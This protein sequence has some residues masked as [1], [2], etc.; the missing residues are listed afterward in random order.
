MYMDITAQITDKVETPITT[1][2]WIASNLRQHN[3]AVKPTPP[4]LR[5]LWGRKALTRLI[6]AVTLLNGSSSWVQGATVLWDGGGDGTSWTDA[7]NWS[8]D[9]IP[10]N[11]DRLII[12]L[13]AT[14]PIIEH[15]SGDHTIEKIAA[16]H[17]ELIF[18]GG[19]LT[20]TDEAW[21]TRGVTL[22]NG[23]IAVTNDMRVSTGGLNLLGGQLGT[24]TLLKI[25]S[26]P[27]VIGPAY[28]GP[29]KAD[30]RGVFTDLTGD[31]AADHELTLIGR[32]SSEF[33]FSVV[34]WL[35]GAGGNSAM[36]NNGTILLSNT[37]ESPSE[38]GAILRLGV[39]DGKTTP[40]DDP[41]QT[42]L[43]LLG[44]HLTNNGT[45]EA[46]QGASIIREIQGKGTL[47]NNP[48]GTIKAE[49]GD[50]NFLLIQGSNYSVARKRRLTGG[51][52]SP[53]RFESAGGNV[54]GPV[55]LAHSELS[56]TASPASGEATIG[57]V[58][59]DNKL[60]T[61]I[62]P[63]TTVVIQGTDILPTG[64][65]GADAFFHALLMLNA[66]EGNDTFTN[67][68]KIVLK[69][70]DI[71]PSTPQNLASA[72]LVLDLQDLANEPP[73]LIKSGNL[74]NEGE[75]EILAPTGSTP[76]QREQEQREIRGSGMF[77]NRGDITAEEG[78][79]LSISG[80]NYDDVWHPMTFKMD[81]GGTI[82]GPVFLQHADIDASGTAGAGGARII[83]VGFDNRLISD[84]IGA[85]NTLAIQ[86]TDIDPDQAAPDAFFHASLMFV[87]DENFSGN[88]DDPAAAQTLT[89]NGTIV[90]RS[91]DLNP[92]NDTLFP[93]TSPDPSNDFELASA[94]LVLDMQDLV[95][96]SNP[97]LP[98]RL[99]IGN[100]VNTGQIQVEAGRGDPLEL[101]E[102]RGSGTIT[103]QGSISVENG[104][105]LTITGVNYGPNSANPDWNQI[106]FK[107]EGGTID[108]SVFFAHAKL[109]VEAATSGSS[110][111]VVGFDNQLISDV[112]GAGNTIIIQG[113]DIDPE[114]AASDAFFHAVLTLNQTE[115][116]SN[117]L[118]NNGT[119]VLKSEDVNP[120]SDAFFPINSPD[121]S[122]DFELASANLVLDFPNTGGGP[123]FLSGNLDNQ[124]QIQVE[125]PQGQGGLGDPLELREI[126]G[127]GTFTNDGTIDVEDNTFLSISGVNFGSTGAP[128]W[129]RITFEAGSTGQ[130]TGDGVVLT[131]H[132]NIDVGE[133]LSADPDDIKSRLHI[134]GFDNRIV[135]DTVASGNEV[136]ILGTDAR[137]DGLASDIPTPD[138]FFHAML[139]FQSETPG[140]SAQTLTNEGR[141]VLDSRD[142][143]DR[144]DK[145]VSEENDFEIASA[146]LVLDHQDLS[147]PDGGQLPDLVRVGNLVNATGGRIH[148]TAGEGG[149]LELR[150]I[151]GTGELRNQGQI[152]VDPGTY[153][154]IS[155]IKYDESS[156]D[157]VFNPITY[158]AD[159]GT[160]EGDAYL[161]HSRIRLDNAAA[162]GST[163]QLV[164]FDNQL[165]PDT[166]VISDQFTLV[167]QG[168]DIIEPP[169]LDTADAFF[170]SV[171]FFLVDT[172]H[173]G[174][175]LLTSGDL[176]P[177]T[178]A[179][180]IGGA[181]LNLSGKLINEGIIEAT[182]D[183]S[184]RVSG[185]VITS[186]V[187]GTF[188][189]RGTLIAPGP[190]R[191][192]NPEDPD[193]PFHNVLSVEVNTNSTGLISGNIDFTENLT[194]GVDA[195]VQIAL[196]G[197]EA[198][199]EHDQVNITQDLTLEVEMPSPFVEEG[200]ALDLAFLD[201]FV[202]DYGDEFEIIRY[203]SREG[204]FVTI[205]DAS[206]I[207]SPQ[208]AL[209]LFYDPFG[210]ANTLTLVATAPGDANGD[211]IVNI[212][213]FG[214]LAGNFNQ[215]GTWE[216]GDFDGN[217]VVDIFDFG[218]LAENFNGDFR[219]LAAAAASLGIGG[220]VPEP[221]TLAILGLSSVLA[222]SSRS[223]RL[224]TV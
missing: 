70:E 128:D 23:T 178:P 22:N 16:M 145:L 42:D 41:I 12:N 98:D 50:G 130:T 121:P 131:Q 172:T 73:E 55:F 218:L 164:G 75:I 141:I 88:P 3:A 97:D 117:T 106:T 138:A 85:G 44:L 140:T 80:V 135:S 119:L 150:E 207:I 125:N 52:Y 204:R 37:N 15:A 134:V 46:K 24:E 123:A 61:D 84:T 171:L 72:N 89:N 182:N 146:N 64:V 78:A 188:D 143:N 25:E 113:A 57:V 216:S 122:N 118:T 144:L 28:N 40:D 49:A 56:I 2:G 219:A 161:T 180:R 223:R 120:D 95:N 132:A 82:A 104:T 32:Q 158:I 33:S 9:V 69:S 10:D 166:E 109:D 11:D 47:T 51:P 36:E 198:R 90:L 6:V 74:I 71:D 162:S 201:G 155:G 4:M 94:N 112:I 126:R 176:N 202:P 193:D 99:R 81:N 58:G 149:D 5:R 200:P 136:V 100:L 160:I 210:H 152:I 206:H 79:L 7:Q 53:I 20:I 220:D 203:G 26:A 170:N 66:Q 111:A 102:I 110:L 92:D 31:L 137:P 212:A 1:S 159:G 156:E 30:V 63:N 209:G 76:E 190:N 148:A 186:E 173:Q 179:D 157:A 29:F 45:I 34:E 27:I 168:T 54:E 65:A 187:G 87:D 43:E 86:G 59:F 105:Y 127:S 93:K 181:A 165:D 175:I 163:V 124:G 62:L 48:G 191:I 18:N 184:G 174:K 67:Q 167:L 17:E 60:S 169:A 195:T 68:G 192:E 133:T 115:A 153:M 114:Q 83:L 13:T 103:N 35:G 208:L 199:S 147:S 224:T 214:L 177:N 77:T 151:R 217:G 39:E 211:L 139:M 91:E 205:K 8:P 185:R 222:L 129:H 107:S 142:L 21:F 19:S 14:D 154:I 116:G 108:G 194:L 101:R 196:G 183:A 221:S 213:D 197:L 215:P 96:S 189:N 38:K